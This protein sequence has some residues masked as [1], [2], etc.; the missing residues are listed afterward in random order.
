MTYLL[1]IRTHIQEL[2]YHFVK[3]KNYS[4]KTKYTDKYGINYTIIK[5]KATVNSIAVIFTTIEKANKFC[6]GEGINTTW[7]N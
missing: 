1:Y 4:Y 7:Q 2:I 5:E 3:G 6:A